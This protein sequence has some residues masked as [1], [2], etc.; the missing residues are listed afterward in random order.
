MICTS[1]QILFSFSLFTNKSLIVPS[2]TQNRKAFSWKALECVHKS[3]N[4]EEEG[5][6]IIIIPSQC[7]TF[8]P[9]VKLI[10]LGK[11]FT[12]LYLMASSYLHERYPLPNHRKETMCA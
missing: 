9:F 4:M 1:T 7:S 10:D 3:W 2:P 5:L 12:H 6:I 11:C 8:I